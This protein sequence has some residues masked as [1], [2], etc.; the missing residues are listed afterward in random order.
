MADAAIAAPELKG[1]AA[2]KAGKK[3]AK[4][5]EEAKGGGKKKILLIVAVLLI[6]VL[7]FVVKTKVMAKPAGPVKPVPGA[8]LATDAMYINLAD[9]HF[10]KMGLGLQ[11][12]A[13]APKTTDAAEAQQ[14]AIFL[15]QGRAIE[16]LM[17]TKK[18]EALR[19]KL[20]AQVTEQ[21]EG[22]I[23]DVYFTSFVMQ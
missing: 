15:F 20:V 5:G 7:G 3:A 6:A 10:L 14:D 4:G 13:S 9:G 23:Y 18:L 12:T 8:V 17:D 1:R 11:E 19:Q 16:E 2:K 22:N 21:S